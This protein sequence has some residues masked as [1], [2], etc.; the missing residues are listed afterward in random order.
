MH[1]HDVCKT[2]RGARQHVL[3]VVFKLWKNIQSEFEFFS[4]CETHLYQKVLALNLRGWTSSIHPVTFQQ[5]YAFPFCSCVRAFYATTHHLSHPLQLLHLGTI[6]HA[7]HIVCSIFEL[8]PQS[9]SLYRTSM[10]H[11]EN[12]HCSLR[13]LAIQARLD[14]IWHPEHGEHPSTSTCSRWML[15]NVC[16]LCP[17]SDLHSL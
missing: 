15:A 7:L 5:G 4:A 6:L 11:D 16:F 3:R 13:H 8:E 10:Y 12:H 1:N 17:Q 9:G 14:S 2:L